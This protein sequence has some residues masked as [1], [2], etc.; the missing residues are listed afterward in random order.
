MSA[1]LVTWLQFVACLVLIGLAGPQLS[2]SADVIADKTGLSGNWI[3]LILVAT[4]TS[5]PELAV[6]ASAVT[7][8]A[9]ADIAVGNVLG[10]C[11]FNLTFLVVLDFL[12]RG[13]SVYRRVGL[14]HVLSA[15]LGV[16]L[17][18]FVG[19]NIL[20]HGQGA[21]FAIGHVGVFTPIV[22]VLY[23]VGMR[24]VFNYE[25]ANLVQAT[26]AAASRYPDMSLRGAM[27]RYGVA[28]AVIVV[29]GI[30]LPF[31]AIDLARV[32]GWST[33]FVGTLF[34]AAVT[35]VPELV[36]SVA[37]IRL[38]AVDMAMATLLG[39]NLFNIVILGLDDILYLPGPILS[40]VSPVHAVSAMSAVIMSGIVMVGLVYRPV[41]RL[42]L[43]VGWI[44]LGLF[45]MYLLNSYVLFL[46][47]G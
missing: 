11:V 10:S 38:G 25:R 4:V 39:S 42:F 44:S 40:H 9:A 23:V 6:G 32:M 15:G 2:R 5:L 21:S 41:T 1:E 14:G 46:H 3:G 16:V 29:A 12:L 33:S 18:G 30:W 7:L 37:A 24:A 26:E 19:L 35:T 43:S 28:A 31:V 8:A 13:E 17:I 47:G 36:V 27:L 34:V 45:V 22:L 20:M